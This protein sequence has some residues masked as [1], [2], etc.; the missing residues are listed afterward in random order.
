M[1]ILLLNWQDIK[2]PYGG[3]AEVYLHQI[4]QRIAAQGHEVT[5]FCSKFHGAPAEEKTDGLHIIRKGN[6]NLFNYAVPF[7]YL[8]HFRHKPYDIV[9]DD[10]NK[11]PF[12]T[13]L[14][15][16]KPLV[17]MVMHLFGKA[18]FK[19]T[20]IPAASY[21]FGAERLALSVY[22]NTPMI[23]ISKSTQDELISN[24]YKEENVF[25]VP[26]AVNHAAYR[27]IGGME[28]NKLS[29][30]YVGR[31]KKYKSVD[32][33]LKAFAVVLKV[34]PGA[35]LTVI[36]EGDGKAMF[37]KLAHELQID[38][39]VA[40]TGFL[41]LDKKII[42]L[43]QMQVV[44]NTSAK[45]GWG[46]TVTEANACGVP[47]I[48]SDVPGLRDAVIDNQTGLLYDYGNIEQLAGKI[49]LLLKDEN[50]RAKLTEGAL[51]YAKSL[52]WNASAKVMLNVIENVVSK[53]T[54]Y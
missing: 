25:L 53:K 47:A 5:L 34:I 42:L 15:V 1:K 4:F 38:H 45:E 13:P 17:G 23:A 35:K 37:Q 11:I 36:G 29:I 21:V 16:K 6:R 43:N 28:R 26:C 2:N 50:L 54:A 40:F 39:A 30:C 48:A 14:F 32:H 49:I 7:E 27:Q 41:P 52:T 51:S 20:S 8:K 31:I 44:V 46:L 18:I 33:L 22:K 3:G 9:I 12:Y 10:I 24:G 19:E